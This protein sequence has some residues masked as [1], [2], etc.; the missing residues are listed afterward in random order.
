MATIQTYTPFDC[1]TAANYKAWSQAI[2]NALATLGW[3]QSKS[4]AIVIGVGNASA[5]NTTYTISPAPAT[6][7]WTA[8]CFVTFANCG[9]SVNNGTFAVVSYNSG[10]GALVVNNASGQS[11]SPTGSATIPIDQYAVNWANVTTGLPSLGGAQSSLVQK[12]IVPAGAWVT[13][14]AYTGGAVA[15]ST[16]QMVTYNGLTYTCFLNT[17]LSA[18]AVIQSTAQTLSAGTLASATGSSGN[19]IYTGT[20]TGGGSNAFAGFVFTVTGFANPLNNGVFVCLA[21]AAGTLTLS[22]PS[23]VSGGTGGTATSITT[24][25]SV[26]VPSNNAYTGNTMVGQT[27]QNALFTTSSG[28]NNV[29]FTCIASSPTYIA[30]TNASG[31]NETRSATTTSTTAP[32]SSLMTGVNAGGFWS[33]YNYEIWCSNGPLSTT[34]PIYLKLVYF[35]TVYAVGANNLA[36]MIIYGIGTATNGSGTITGN[37]FDPQNQGYADYLLMYYGQNTSGL[38]PTYECDFAGDA[39]NFRMLLWR[40]NGNMMS[41]IIIDRGRDQYGNGVAAY[42]TACVVAGGS[43]A[44]ASAQQSVFQP[45]GGSLGGY[46]TS[47]WIIPYFI[48]SG[49]TTLT[50]NANGQVP[51]LPIFPIVGFVG[52]PLLGTVAFKQNDVAEGALVNVVFFGT[53][54]TYLCTKQAGALTTQVT[55]DG[56]FGILWQ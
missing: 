32:P 14:T 12:T 2:S 24:S 27:F 18:S 13:N 34:S 22:N 10:T 51:P 21:S 28:A 44:A 35:D 7:T 54:Y 33:P 53:S 9:G 41:S 29:S 48:G 4:S 50:G 23:G 8:G 3:V 55:S 30:Y 25:S 16:C 39:D 45:G 40:N 20:I 36:P 43:T 31:V 47:H 19:T 38:V 5:G 42:W 49:H 46:T 11:A 37:Y 52:N 56:A 26:T 15:N 1:T 6:G 17:Q